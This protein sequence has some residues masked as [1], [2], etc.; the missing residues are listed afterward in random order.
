[1][2]VHEKVVPLI[3]PGFSAAE[4]HRLSDEIIAA[5]GYPT[6]LTAG[7]GISEGYFHTLGHGVGLE[8]HEGPSLA[9]NG[10]SLVAGDIITIEPGIYRAGFGGCRIE[11]LILVTDDGYENLTDFPYEL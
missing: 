8:I 4:L 6:I 9:P 5:H 1:M 11:D 10:E 3:R 7:A 2:E